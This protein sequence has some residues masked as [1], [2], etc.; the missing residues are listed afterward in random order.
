MST[1]SFSQFSLQPALLQAVAAL[2]WQHPTAIQQAVIPLLLSGRDVEAVAPTGTGKTAAFL[3]PLLERLSTTPGGTAPRG[4]VLSPTR[5]LAEQIGASLGR[6]GAGLSV[7]HTVLVGGT[8]E[9]PQIAALEEGCDVVVATPGR[10]LDLARR[11][12]LD[13]GAV[14]VL[15]IDEADRLLD[16]G[17]WPDLDAIRAMLPAQRQGILLSATMPDAVAGVVA[18]FL[19]R[20][21]KVVAEEAAPPLERIEQQVMFVRKADKHQLLAHVLEGRDRVMVFTRTRSG[22]DR[23]VELLATR[24]REAIALH[25]QKSQAARRAALEAFRAGEAGVLIATDVAARGLHIE[26]VRCV[27]SFDLPSEPETYIHRIGRTGRMGQP[28]EAVAMCDPGEYDYLRAIEALCGKPLRPILSHPF[29]DHDLLPPVGKPRK[30][31]RPKQRG[32]RRRR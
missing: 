26:G 1:E 10:L 8:S 2:G 3:L 15:V 17:F 20:P 12:L 24:G 29:H 22:A 11:G 6:L 16:L 25:G 5:E 13:L 32:R 28:G 30:S 31:G 9:A 19:S 23:A 18:A 4:L 14:S 7:R 27:V 21:E